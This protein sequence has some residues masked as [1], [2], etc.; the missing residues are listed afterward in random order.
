MDSGGAPEPLTTK[1]FRAQTSHELRE[2]GMQ[3][4]PRPA[5]TP[6]QALSAMDHLIATHLVGQHE[7]AQQVGMNVTDLTCFAYVMEA[8]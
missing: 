5:A 7:I 1:P 6:E 8:A 3:A 2:L 4:K